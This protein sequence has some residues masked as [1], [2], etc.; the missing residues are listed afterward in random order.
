MQGSVHVLFSCEGL[1][2]GWK[3]ECSRF[4]GV[5]L[6]DLFQIDMPLLFG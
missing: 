4:Y 6:A 2:I 3:K 5:G 1:I